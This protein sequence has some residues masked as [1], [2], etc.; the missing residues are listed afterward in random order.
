MR[1]MGNCAGRDGILVGAIHAL[2]QVAF[3][4]RLALSLKFGNPLAVATRT[5]Q[6]FRPSDLLEMSN[7]P[8]FSIE[9]LEVLRNRCLHFHA[10]SVAWLGF[11]ARG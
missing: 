2:A 8:L 7:A 6:P 10:Q 11:F 9:L 5:A 3:F 1:V 4:P